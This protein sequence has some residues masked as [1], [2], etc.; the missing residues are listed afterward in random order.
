MK[1]NRSSVAV[2]AL[3]VAGALRVSAQVAGGTTTTNL[4]VTQSTKLAAG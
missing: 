2:A 4:S 1:K 3:T